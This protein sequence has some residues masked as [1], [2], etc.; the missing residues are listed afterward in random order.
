MDLIIVACL[1]I[2]ILFLII[3]FHVK[4][5]QNIKEE[6]KT[7]DTKLFIKKTQNYN[8]VFQ[9]GKYTIWIPKPINDYYP[10]GNYISLDKKPPK[11]MA[12]L[13]KNNMGL[14]SKDKPIKYDIISITNN[15]YA[16]WKPISQPKQ[17]SLG[18]IVS[19]EYPSKYLIRTIP[20]KYCEKS[21]VN[22][23]IVKNKISSIDKGYELWNIDESNLFVCNNL[24]NNNVSNIKKVYKLNDNYLNIEKKLYIKT[25]NSYKKICSYN[26]TKLNKTFFI[27]RPITTPNFCSLGDIILTQDIDPNK[28]L[29]TIVVHKSFC[30]IPINYGSKSIYKIKQKNKNINIWR[31]KHHNDYYFFGDIVV[32]GDGQPE[33]DNLIYSIS[34]DY[35][36]QIKN[37]T[38]NLVYNNVSEKNPLSI[39][40]DINNFFVA[41]NSYN[42][43]NKNKYELNMNFIKTDFDSTDIRKPIKITFKKK[44]N[45]KKI[46]DNDLLNLVKKTL[47]DK[48]DIRYDRLHDI[49]I[50]KKNI[51]LNISPK[52][53]SSTEN[54]INKCIKKL[55]KLLEIEP[56]KIYNKNKDIYYI[57][58]FKMYNT[59]DNN[60]IELD[61][62]QFNR[63]LNK[64]K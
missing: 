50:D 15:N 40:S 6:F 52:R 44:N 11:E 17:I 18:H 5:R 14:D 62:S 22:K 60:I 3:Y 57:S 54:T 24:N 38:H 56:L 2:V 28:T 7:E 43:P 61:N 8:K 29:D 35:I 34:V 31:P 30:K 13:V 42:I 63:V 58:L 64:N 20:K 32:I 16:I 48:I 4:Q 49:S 53:A 41:N 25:I 47:C 12:I 39:W 46:K 37:T 36:K 55:S 45:I 21:N 27:W 1:F 26:D 9:N 51:M 23:L 33:A 59:T 19:K 10:I